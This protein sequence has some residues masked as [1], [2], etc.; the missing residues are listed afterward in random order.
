MGP[1]RLNP[2]L[3]WLWMLRGFVAGLVRGRLFQLRALARRLLESRSGL[4]A[5]H[6]LAAVSQGGAVRYYRP[7]QDERAAAAPPWLPP[8]WNPGTRALTTTGNNPAP[9]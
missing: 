6:C 1:F 9:N 2:G 8:G 3:T 7:A 4:Q 5:K